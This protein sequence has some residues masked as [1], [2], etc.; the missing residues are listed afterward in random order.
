MFWISTGFN[1]KQKKNW[2][3]VGS[4]V[5]AGDIAIVPYGGG[6]H[7]KGIR[8]GGKGDVTE[9][10]LLW[11]RTGTG[12]FVP[13]P[14]VAYGKIFVLHDRGEVHCID[15]K[16]GKSHWEDAFPRASSSYYASPTVAG[17]FL[18]APREDG[19]I[20]IA[21]ISKGFEFHGKF[22]KSERVIAYSVPINEKILIRGEKNL[23]C[24]GA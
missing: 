23:M 8:M 16:T 19:V 1:P 18:Y 4:H 3:V 13:T 15:P 24:F 12:Y 5:V 11:S 20:L 7:M 10:N 21:D 14:A 22:D 9:S 17:N 2:V 6:T